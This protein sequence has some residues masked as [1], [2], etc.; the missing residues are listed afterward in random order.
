MSKTW[1]TTQ[2]IDFIEDYYAARETDELIENAY[3]RAYRTQCQRELEL[4][5]KRRNPDT[6]H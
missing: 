5:E 2:V 4:W 3:E 6:K 1:R